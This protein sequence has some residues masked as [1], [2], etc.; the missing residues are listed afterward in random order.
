MSG[1]IF[2]QAMNYK[3]LFPPFCRLSFEVANAGFCH[4]EF[5]LSEAL[6][7]TEYLLIVQDF[8]IRK[9]NCSFN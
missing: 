8:I 5:C 3:K 4:V 2:G 9:Q 7:L 6:S 1:D